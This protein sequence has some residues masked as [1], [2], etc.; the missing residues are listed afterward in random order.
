MVYDVPGRAFDPVE[1]YP[2]IYKVSDLSRHEIEQ[3]RETTEDDLETMA[4]R[5]E[6]SLQGL[7]RRMKKLGLA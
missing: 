3:A 5:L 1:H 6:I 7:K 4:E 2:E